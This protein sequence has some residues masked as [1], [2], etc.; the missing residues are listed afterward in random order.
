M[1][2]RAGR[3]SRQG[4]RIPGVARRKTAAVNFAQA[5]PGPPPS[6]D[7]FESGSEECRNLRHLTKI[8]DI[9]F[10]GYYVSVTFFAHHGGFSLDGT[11]GGVQ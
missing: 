1:G 9:G 7:L 2:W 8:H 4:A 5:S 6:G 3:Q 11:G 10:N